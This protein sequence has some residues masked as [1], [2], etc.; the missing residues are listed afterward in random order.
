MGIDPITHKP[1]TDAFGSASGNHKDV[2]NLSQMA[3]WESARLEAEA[4]LGRESKLVSNPPQNQLAASSSSS[5]TPFTNNAVA[6]ATRSQYLD[7]LKTWQYVVVRLF[8]FNSDNF[9]SPTSTLN[10]MENTLPNLS[11]GFNDNFIGNSSIPCK[12]GNIVKVESSRNDW[13]CLEKSD[14]I[15]ELKERLDSSMGLH[16][17]AYSSKGEW[18]QDSYKT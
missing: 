13:K 12:G 1:K 11:V 18:F 17:M 3:Q 8:T 16:E 7:I 15:S 6:P 14:Q 10:F 2:A 9:Q 5:S 4:R